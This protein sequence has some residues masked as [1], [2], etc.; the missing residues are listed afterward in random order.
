MGQDK[1]ISPYAWGTLLSK[2]LEHDL[3]RLLSQADAK[4]LSGAEARTAL[5][6]QLRSFVDLKSTLKSCK[7]RSNVLQPS[8]EAL[9]TL[10]DRLFATAH[11]ALLGDAK[12]REGQ[13]STVSANPKSQ[14]IAVTPPARFPFTGKL[15][16]AARLVLRRPRGTEAREQPTMSLE[17]KWQHGVAVPSEQFLL[18]WQLVRLKAARERLI[19]ELADL[20]EKHPNMFRRLKLTDAVGVEVESARLR[21]SGVWSKIMVTVSM[22]GAPLQAR[23]DAADSGQSTQSNTS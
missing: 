17:K 1:Y 20:S 7:Q 16:M 15:L 5:F 14:Q 21:V 12:A 6:E 3:A 22:S 13:P 8:H 9:L 11:Q 2:L 18:Q 23:K 10:A 4:T 19:L